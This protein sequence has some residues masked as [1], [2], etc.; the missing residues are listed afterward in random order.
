M[1]VVCATATRMMLSV[2][3]KN[4]RLQNLLGIGHPPYA[5]LSSRLGAGARRKSPS[6]PA[7]ASAR[8]FARRRGP[9]TLAITRGGAS[10]LRVLSR[11]EPWQDCI[12]SPLDLCAKEDQSDEKPSVMM[13]ASRDVDRPRERWRA[14][15][16]SVRAPHQGP[17]EE[18]CR[19]RRAPER[20][21]GRRP[22]RCPR[23][24]TRNDQHWSCAPVAVAHCADP[25]PRVAGPSPSVNRSRTARS[26]ARARMAIEVPS[27]RRRT[28]G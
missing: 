13:Y 3:R 22:C 27:T 19:V 23:C 16:A 26:A 21:E 1:L 24:C 12:H 7:S 17:D 10:G 6:L 28:E 5:S 4:S 11:L 9:G 8:A 18:P 20:A 14:E 25:I 2:G 15:V